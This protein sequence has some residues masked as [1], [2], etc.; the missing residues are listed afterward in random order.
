M[1]GR[2]FSLICLAVGCGAIASLEAAEGDH[3]I[4]LLIEK[5]AKEITLEMIGGYRMIDPRTGHYVAAGTLNKKYPLVPLET[6]LRWGDEYP[7]VYQV[8]LIPRG[9]H[10]YAR[11]NG[12]PCRGVLHIYQIYGKLSVVNEIGI[13]E[14]VEGE[15]ATTFP[16]SADSTVMEA[17]AIAARTHAH[18]DVE[19]GRASYW[20]IEKLGSKPYGRPAAAGR[21]DISQVVKETAGMVL[22][23][24]QEGRRTFPAEWTKHSAGRTAPYSLLFRRETGLPLEGR[25]TPWA[26]KVRDESK[27][28][29][30][31]PA[32]TFAQLVGIRQICEVSLFAD[33]NSSKVYAIRVNDGEKNHDLDFFT[34]Q[35]HLGA[36]YLRSS[37][38]A[39]TL[40]KE[41][42][43]FEGYG[44][45]HGV[46]LCLHSAEEMSHR[47]RNAYQILMTFFPDSYLHALPP[48]AHPISS[49][50]MVARG[51]AAR[52]LA[53]S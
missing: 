25:D 18:F 17:V 40:E 4:R 1:I 12:R 46:G 39:V 43:L 11:V 36:E 9:R 3:T 6:G 29:F 50:P 37:D 48:P 10:G 44:E 5:E 53:D 32:E 31:I 22:L 8:T 16:E 19:R 45:G 30:H 34:L 28:E 41:E 27:W 14:Y 35:R 13:E 33:P 21:E 51:Y 47:G 42:L 24:D 7:G 49:G 2:W 26:G 23:Y 38:F 20:H 52:H 15:L